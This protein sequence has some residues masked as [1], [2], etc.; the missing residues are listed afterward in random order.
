M[1]QKTLSFTVTIEFA[2]SIYDDNQ[3]I[4]VAENIAEAIVM[5]AT[6][7]MGIAP[8]DGDT[9]M[10]SVTVKPMFLDTEIHKNVL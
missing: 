9:Y 1:S 4:Q 10:T 3:T 5:E 7:N 8:E 2:D 6:N